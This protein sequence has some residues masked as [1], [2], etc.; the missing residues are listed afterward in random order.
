MEK[1]MSRTLIET[2][3]KKA[4]ESIKDSPERGIR[5]L[6]D[7]ALQFSKGRF[8][9]NFFT[10]TQTM[11]QNEN[12][13][14]YGLVRNIV[15]HT[16][17]ERLF[18]F[19]MNLGYNSCT[20]G[21]RRIRNNEETMQCSIPW[22]IALHVDTQRVTELQERY[23]ALIQ[24]GESLGIFTWML[25]ALENPEEVLPLI[26]THTDSAFCIF[27]EP[28]D[29]SASFLDTVTDL[30]NVMLVVRYDENMSDLCTTLREMGLL[31]SVWYP[32]GQKDMEIIIN[33]DLFSSAQ[34]LSPAFTVL[35]P[36]MNCPDE[37]RKLA[38]QAVK[39]ARK[40]QSY[41]TIVLDFQGDTCLIDSII[42]GDKCSVSFNKT[43]ALC[44]WA[45]SDMKE[46]YNIF[47]NSLSD[48]LIS[49]S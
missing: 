38:Y 8:Q 17:T 16:D 34:Q 10:V 5:N 20:E 48:I 13:A 4:L 31:Y 14:Y 39:T 40:E 18:T 42:S 15:T 26:E 6:V 29:L 1:T 19:G 2:V 28:D 41:Q 43:G 9:Q 11:L 3:V 33:G 27:C 49:I 46:Q 22:T 37:I 24:E 7:M 45:K 12:S 23:D 25:F 35:V 47:Q 32:Y 30:K 36:Q 44:T 21:A